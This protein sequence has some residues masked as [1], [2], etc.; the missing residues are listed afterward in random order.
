MVAREGN[1]LHRHRKPEPVRR[2]REGGFST[3]EVVVAA[4]IFAIALVSTGLS[5][6]VG[7]HSQDESEDFSRAL[8]AVRD[9]CAEMQERANLPQNLPALE[10]I[11][12]VYAAHNGTTRTINDLPNGTLSIICFGNETSVPADF[13]GPMD[14]NFDGDANDNHTGQANGSDL[15]LVPVEISVSFTDDRG[16]VTQVF[17]RT[18]AQTTD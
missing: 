3:V 9:V 18:F 8:R 16:T 15:Q 2:P 7:A 17:H 14:L 4:S 5:L 1:T 12:A 13:G 11:G 10:G 6:L